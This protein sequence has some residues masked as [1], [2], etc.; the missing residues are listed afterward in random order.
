MKI[1]TKYVCKNKNVEI[2]DLKFKLTMEEFDMIEIIDSIEDNRPK[3]YDKM[4]EVS[5]QDLTDKQAYMLI[6]SLAEYYSEKRI[7]EQEQLKKGIKTPR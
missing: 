1:T 7:E 3:A 5:G 4:R 2:D 6:S